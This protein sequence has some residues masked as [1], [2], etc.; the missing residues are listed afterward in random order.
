M[1]LF[2]EGSEKAVLKTGT[3]GNSYLKTDLEKLKAGVFG[4][5]KMTTN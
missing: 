3:S 4:K 5:D 1:Q 2:A